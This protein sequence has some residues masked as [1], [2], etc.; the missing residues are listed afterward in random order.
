M[1]EQTMCDFCKRFDL[2]SA[3][4]E[5][6]KY[7]ARIILAGGSYH[8]PEERMFSYCPVCGQFRTDI[9]LERER[10]KNNDN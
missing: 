5:T 7:G 3:S 10:T 4:T 9:I 6:D 2:G 8:F 1:E